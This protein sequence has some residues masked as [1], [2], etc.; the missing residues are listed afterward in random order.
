[1]PTYGWL[2]ENALDISL[3][4]KKIRAMQTMGVP[5]PKGYDKIAP[6]D[7]K[8]QAKIIAADILANTPNVALKGLNKKKL[9]K[10]IEKSEIVALIAYMQRLGIDIKTNKK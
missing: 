9:L 4:E 8:K 3:T 10:E 2:R 7:L 5:Y 1:M 6:K